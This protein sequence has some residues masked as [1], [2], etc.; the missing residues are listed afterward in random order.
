VALLRVRVA[1][2]Q[3]VGNDMLS[4]YFFDDTGFDAQSAADAVS[5]FWTELAV[6]L[7]SDLSGHIETDVAVIDET[8]GHLSGV[9]P[10]LAEDPLSGGG[11]NNP[12]PFATQG[13]V[14]WS[15][16]V[17]GAHRILTGR[18]FIPGI[19]EENS[20]FGQPTSTIVDGITL[21]TSHFLS[22]VSGKFVIWHRPTPGH[23]GA[24]FPVTS[25]TIWNQFAVLRSRRS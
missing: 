20:T 19:T 21:A 3:T 18:T 1:L 23:D 10:I 7:S 13:L 8:T 22:D 16:G 17:V 2:N 9:H 5:A 11:S 15:T 14:K 25:A 12:L 24:A 6:L 4:T